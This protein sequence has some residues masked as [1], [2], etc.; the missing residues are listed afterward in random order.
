[1][2]AYDRFWDVHIT[3]D[4]GWYDFAP[5]IELS[6]SYQ[7]RKGVRKWESL[8]LVS[9]E[10]PK[11]ASILQSKRTPDTLPVTGYIASAVKIGNLRYTEE[12]ENVRRLVQWVN[13]PGYVGKARFSAHGKSGGRIMMNEGESS[14]YESSIK[15]AAIA[16]WLIDNGLNHKDPGHQDRA[17]KRKK[18]EL[19]GLVTLCLDFCTA[20]KSREDRGE[21][22]S[23]ITIQSAIDQVADALTRENL[24]SIKVTG[25]R[26]SVG[27]RLSEES[28]RETTMRKLLRDGPIKWH[29]D[30]ALEKCRE[31]VKELLAKAPP[32][33]FKSTWE[34]KIATM[35]K[36]ELI[37]LAHSFLFETTVAEVK[38]WYPEDSKP[39]QWGRFEKRGDGTE[40]WY[41]LA[42]TEQSNEKIFKWS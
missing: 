8:M 32:S 15:A 3:A 34:A 4:N 30:K 23:V 19:K 12:S 35:A 20:A 11:E 18:G 22:G 42:H 14:K 13:D 21:G 25:S 5:T 10:A 40:R 1:M 38:A 37:N 2:P 28:I 16:A 29:K 33:K 9:P 39:G 6:R 27:I 7:C 26:D 17:L 31:E 24:F 41:R 36:H